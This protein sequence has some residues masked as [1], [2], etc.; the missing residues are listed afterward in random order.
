MLI[1]LSAFFSSM[2]Q[3]FL[4]SCLYWSSKLV[5]CIIHIFTIPSGD[6]DIMLASQANSSY[7]DY[8]YLYMRS[9][10]I[11]F[12]MSIPVD[13]IFGP[14]R[15]LY[16][17]VMFYRAYLR[18]EQADPWQMWKRI[19][20]NVVTCKYCRLVQH[21]KHLIHTCG[22]WENARG[23]SGRI[24]FCFSHDDRGYALT[25]GNQF[26]FCNWHLT[27]G[28]MNMYGFLFSNPAKTLPDDLHLV[29]HLTIDYLHGD[30]PCYIKF[31]ARKDDIVVFTD[32]DTGQ[33][34]ANHI[35]SI[36]AFSKF[37][38]LYT[39]FRVKRLKYRKTA[40]GQFMTMMTKRRFQ[41]CARSFW[42]LIYD[43]HGGLLTTL[44]DFAC[45]SQKRF[46]ESKPRSLRLHHCETERT[47]LALGI[48]TY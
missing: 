27:P 23:M 45:S 11:R 2:S 25:S 31:I 15:D 24:C 29:N 6:V 17:R 3:R 14:D 13:T 47:P 43:K 37:P 19:S 41:R 5:F 46:T 10:S 9:S 22:W 33:L 1:Y 48:T 26:V 7:D 36:K 4:R 18:G 42:T 40:L 39:M 30:S 35:L 20:R 12:D 38:R 16:C 28:K 21:N 32:E 44:G 34:L 8:V